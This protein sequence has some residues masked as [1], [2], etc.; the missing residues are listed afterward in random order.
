MSVDPE[1]AER[2]LFS[3]RSS[4]AIFKGANFFIVQIKI[5]IFRSQLEYSRQNIVMVRFQAGLRSRFHSV[6]ITMRNNLPINL[7]YSQEIRCPGFNI[8]PCAPDC[9]G[10]AVISKLRNPKRKLQRNI[11]RL[12]RICGSVHVCPDICGF[13]C[14]GRSEIM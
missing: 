6:L 7:L 14:I 12:R 3:G 9:R 10:K 1:S 8:L 5:V 4:S 13:G 11:F 2:R